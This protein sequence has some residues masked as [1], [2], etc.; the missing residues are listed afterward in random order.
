MR[1]RFFRAVRG[2]DTGLRPR[3][4]GLAHARCRPGLAEEPE[5]GHTPRGVRR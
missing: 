2:R 1:V 5:R 4:V 3:V